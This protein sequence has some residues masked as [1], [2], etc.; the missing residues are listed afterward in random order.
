MLSDKCE[1]YLLISVSVIGHFS[2]L[3]LFIKI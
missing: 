2:R 1:K 3:T